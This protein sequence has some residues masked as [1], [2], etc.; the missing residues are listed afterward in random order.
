MPTFLRSG[1]KSVSERPLQSVLMT[2]F[3]A[4]V[5]VVGKYCGRLRQPRESEDNEP[6]RL[7]PVLGYDATGL[8][9]ARN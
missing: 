8:A 5:L 2:W 4:L 6:S 1:L 3:S 7:G 9:V